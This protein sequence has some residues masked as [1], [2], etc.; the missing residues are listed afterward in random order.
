MTAAKN[1]AEQNSIWDDSVLID[2]WNQALEEYKKYHSIHA[3][4]GSLSDFERE[5]PSGCLDAC[6]QEDDQADGLAE[7]IGPKVDDARAL[8]AGHDH[9]EDKLTIGEHQVP[10][11]LAAE[12][13]DKLPTMLPAHEALV[14]SGLDEDV[15]RM[16][17]SW[18]YAGYYT[19]LYEGR[20]QAQQSETAK[21]S[22][23]TK[24]SSPR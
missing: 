20:K 17:M 10:R 19:G 18:Y 8:L 24:Q 21:Q 3:K 2:S 22:E 11:G 15:K 4:G 1:Q 12:G 6:K 5:F 16:M 23:I 13:G 14:G 9:P 7:P